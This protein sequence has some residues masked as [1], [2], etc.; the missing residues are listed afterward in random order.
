MKLK[1]Q[2]DKRSILQILR[3]DSMFWPMNPVADQFARLLNEQYKGH[4]YLSDRSLLLIREMRG[5][6]VE[7]VFSDGTSQIIPKP[8]G[9]EL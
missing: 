6:E 1:V 7:V 4:Y 8:D 5:V 3:P 2:T 9:S